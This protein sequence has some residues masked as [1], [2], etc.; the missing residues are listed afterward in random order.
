MFSVKPKRHLAK[1]LAGYGFI[2][3]IISALVS[4]SLNIWLDFR[5]HSQRLDAEI[6]AILLTYRDPVN[7][8]VFNIDTD[9][10]E[11]YLNSIITNS[12]ITR[13]TI[14]QHQILGRTTIAP[15]FADRTER[16]LNLYTHSGRP[17]VRHQF[18]TPTYEAAKTPRL[19]LFKRT[20]T[21][22][23][24]DLDHL[25]SRNLSATNDNEYGY[26]E[27]EI[28]LDLAYAPFISRAL[29]I[30]S[31]TSLLML[32][33][34]GLLFLV[35]YRLATKPI[36]SII[37]DLSKVDLEAKSPQVLKSQPINKDDE[38]G[39][40]VDELNGFIR[41]AECLISQRDIAHSS[42]SKTFD[43][44]RHLVDFLPQLI[45]ITNK[46]GFVKLTNK[47]FRQL[48]GIH[49][50]TLERMHRS[51]LANY[52]DQRERDFL[53]APDENVIRTGNPI[54]YPEVSIHDLHKERRSFEVSKFSIV[55]GN[56]RSCLTVAIDTTELR[57]SAERIHHLAY[58]DALTD[59]PN[60]TMF[61]DRLNRAM[62]R[63]K[64]NN[65]VS[66][67]LFI[68]LD[69]FKGIN[70][71][72]GHAAGDEHLRHIARQLQ[73]M[74]RETDTVARLGGDEFVICLSDI[75]HSLEEATELTLKR[76]M[77][78]RELVSTPYESQHRKVFVSA[79]IGISFF[80]CNIDNALNLLKSADTAMYHAKS[81]GKNTEVIY[82]PEMGEA[83]NDRVLMENDLREALDKKEFF[84]CYQPQVNCLTNE[85]TGF[86]ALL[87]WQHPQRGLVSPATFIPL[88]EASRLITQVGTWV[89]QECCKTVAKLKEQQ[90]WLPLMRMSINVSPYQFTQFSFT[91]TVLEAV[92]MAGIQA[93]DLDLEVTE[94]ML[95]HSF[96]E[97]TNRMH[98]L[99][100]Y[101]VQFSIDDFGTG[102]SSLSYIKMLPVNVLKIDQSFVRDLLLDDNDKAIVTSILA[103]AKHLGLETVAEGVEQEEQLDFI[104]DYGCHRFQGYY[105]SKPLPL[106]KLIE[107]LSTAHQPPLENN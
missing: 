23:S 97:V 91:Q 32:S 107:L 41:S 30:I 100:A 95:I 44:I 4:S 7:L 46:D 106:T 53:L 1:K 14:H 29:W 31:I 101:G 33:F 35:F 65:T 28:D 103:M 2:F 92:D 56:D 99:K 3:A 59:L 27:L 76:S 22:S 13:V 83:L 77:R 57:R 69:G 10:I 16:E 37:H 60:R 45:F 93:T 38:I 6:N 64:R 58:H 84:L 98:E 25:D 81:M 54:L 68:D 51:E 50:E 104:K 26:L 67:L 48:L 18:I 43:E 70:D 78:I 12:Y 88:L 19:R 11:V 61:I 34:A 5:N 75:S 9:A 17:H 49:K 90:L 20:V 40:L 62:I 55:F 24:A 74:V 63:A 102:Y 105:F 66:A 21:H 71:G 42:L 80:P 36:L 15:V 79:S 52:F 47:K 94:G 85:I 87:R 72:F 86:E 82:R 73:T 96:N 89:L 8:A 39:Q